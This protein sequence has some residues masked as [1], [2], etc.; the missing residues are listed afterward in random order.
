MDPDPPP[1]TTFD[2]DEK[3]FISD[4][5][6]AE[7][8]YAA[9]TSSPKKRHVTAHLILPCVKRLNPASAG[10]AENTPRPLGDL[11]DQRQ[12]EILSVGPLAVRGSWREW[13][14]A[15]LCG[16]GVQLGHW[17]WTLSTSPRSHR[18]WRTPQKPTSR[19]SWPK[20]SRPER[21]QRLHVLGNA[22]W[23][24]TRQQTANT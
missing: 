17:N 8:E 22:D 5:E 20:W 1:N 13:I 24:E 16:N 9:V 23:P 6:V 19:K 10:S 14:M 18:S 11:A 2:E 15:C 21:L 12:F 3:R 4:A 7:I